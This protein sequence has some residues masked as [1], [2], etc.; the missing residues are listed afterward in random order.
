MLRRTTVVA[1]IYRFFQTVPP[2][3]SSCPYKN[4]L[5]LQTYAL[6]WRA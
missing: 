3:V 4:T 1:P 6:S 5:F 2:C